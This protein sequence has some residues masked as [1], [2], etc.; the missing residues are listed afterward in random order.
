MTGESTNTK[1]PVSYAAPVTPPM[2]LP[3][4]PVVPM[5]ISSSS[6]SQRFPDSVQGTPLVLG[7][8]GAGG[9]S[10]QSAD[11]EQTLRNNKP[12]NIS[13]TSNVSQSGGS[14]GNVVDEAIVGSQ[15]SEQT[16]SNWSDT[17]SETTDIAE[18]AQHYR[19]ESSSDTDN[20]HAP[21]RGNRYAVSSPPMHAEPQATP[22]PCTPPHRR[23]TA[24]RAAYAKRMLAVRKIETEQKQRQGPGGE[25]QQAPRKGKGRELHNK[26]SR[27]PR[28]GENLRPPRTS[29]V[30][31]VPSTAQPYYGLQQGIDPFV[32]G[33]AED[34]FYDADLEDAMQTASRQLALDRLHRAEDTMFANTRNQL[35]TAFNNSS[36]LGTP[37]LRS[38][39]SPG[40]PVSQAQTPLDATRFIPGRAGAYQVP[41]GH[42]WDAQRGGVAQ[43]GLANA[44]YYRPPQNRME[45]EMVARR[46]R[47]NRF[48]TENHRRIL[49]GQPPLMSI[50]EQERFAPRSGP[51]PPPAFRAR[52]DTTGEV[53]LRGVTPTLTRNRMERIAVSPPETPTPMGAG[54]F[55]RVSLV[56]D[57][58]E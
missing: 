9:A 32:L 14:D 55:G 31:P 58:D 27:G 30:C 22:A 23:L 2:V 8:S 16:D 7:T 11:M 41:P 47:E 56:D 36:N 35:L 57:D 21:P 20:A 38:L 37:A 28:V 19:K 24:D 17:E 18:P 25:A 6:E 40:T 53:F 12:G 4:L 15:Q 13:T 50:E 39:Q 51:S 33:L 5:S 43:Q 42:S 44:Q 46:V 1:L 52:S 10:S 45:Q 49:A 29:G 3:R 54:G 34:P 48:R 26:V